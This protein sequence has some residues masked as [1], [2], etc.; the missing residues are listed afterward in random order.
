MDNSL[1]L[2]RHFARLVWLLANEPDEVAEQKAQLR[3]TVTVS[4]D[5][6]ARLLVSEG[7]L[8][9]ND[10]VLPQAL[11][12]VVDL[13][14]Q[15]TAHRVSALEID[16]RAKA[17]ELLAVARLLAARGATAEER[18]ELATQLE[19]YE[20][21]TV[22]FMRAA[23][24]VPEA[25]AAPSTIDFS[26]FESDVRVKATFE[27]LAIATEPVH[28]Q[29]L[30]DELL[31]VVEQA[32]RE[33]RVATAAS[34]CTGL[35]DCEARVT[36][37][38]IRR[39]YLV[40]MRRLTKPGFLQPIAHLIG[41]DEAHSADV[42]RILAR[43][44]QDGVDAA[45][46][47]YI[48]ATSK[49]ER[50]LYWEALSGGLP[51]TRE[52]LLKMLTDPR[53]YVVRQASQLLGELKEADVER[54]LSELLSHPDD[55]VRRGAVR[56]LNRFDS[57]FVFDALA[58]ALGDG[59]ASVRLAA[60]SAL[61]TRKSA[62]SAQLLSQAIDDETETE[63]QFALLAALGRMGTP[64]AVQKLTRA[65][66]AASGF[67]KS[68]KVAAL[69]V[70]AVHALAEARTP[71]AMAAVQVLLNDKEREVRDAAKV[72]LTAPRSTAA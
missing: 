63:V 41:A 39:L 62:R 21:Q 57:A 26:R 58:R 1:S 53:W 22:R 59:A 56:A 48:N 37:P 71:T 42:M 5:T 50:A 55:R 61:A 70:A 72:A 69:R 14:D 52:S 43:F 6:P 33:G 4:K 45:V 7:R 47:Q 9:V 11:A 36:D 31:F 30:L 54:P 27:Q 16:Q 64:D 32:Q 29:Q 12:G 2:A 19:G 24:A 65:A 18:R 34:V 60:V 51:D 38:E 68:K 66:E 15:L 8:V 20:G 3:A 28:A 17:K 10:V 49:S 13:A 35:L 46:D 44:G 25:A 40:A 23:A 67:F